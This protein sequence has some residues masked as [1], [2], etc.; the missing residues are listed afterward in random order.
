MPRFIAHK[1]DRRDNSELC[2][3]FRDAPM[4]GAIRIALEREPDFFLCAGVQTEQP[5]VY[6]GHDSLA[7]Q[8]NERTRIAAVFSTGGRHVFV[9]GKKRFVRYFSDLRILP[10]YRNGTLLARGFHWI[11]ANVMRGTE[12]A[13][14]IIVADNRKAIEYLGSGRAGLPFYHPAGAY[15]THAVSL[16]SRPP[17]KRNKNLPALHIR[18]AQ[19][20]DMAA[21]QK[22]LDREGPRKQFYPCYEF[23]KLDKDYYHGLKISD[24]WLALHGEQLVGIAG[25][26]D[27]R[28]FKQTRIV[29]YAPLIA[30]LR[31]LLNL[32][33][34]FMG[35]IRLPP[36]NSVLQYFF[37]HTILIQDN[38]PDIFRALL[39]AVYR[40]H[41]NSEFEYFL[42]GLD[43]LDPLNA[44]L[45][46]FVRRKFHGRHFLVSF[47]REHPR[48]HLRPGPYYLEAARI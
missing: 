6:A 7:A 31:P 22:L 1:A 8:S 11:H 4:A 13:Q 37:L 10:E 20:N 39:H 32:L 27:Q 33:R 41:R 35:G 15:I 21:M 47:D 5:E 45:E 46:G 28:A 43:A 38:N 26:W 24:F 14:T 12:F 48:E 36:A 29:S 3:L 9:N 16:Q 30:T 42:C 17:R 2:A 34:R 18:R 44:A 40:A 23:Q 19:S 25:V